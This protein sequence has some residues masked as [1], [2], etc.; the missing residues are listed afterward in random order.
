MLPEILA[1]AMLVL[2]ALAE[3]RHA[4]R[5]HSIRFLAFGPRGKPAAW[6]RSV[7]FIRAVSMTAVTWGL[8]SLLWTVEARTHN[9]DSIPEQDIRHLVLIVDV[10]PSMGLLDAGSAGKLTRRQ[11]ASEIVESVFNRISLRQF[12]ITFIAVYSDAKPLLEDSSDHEVVRHMLESMPMWHAF[13]SGKTNLMSGIELAAKMA[14]PWNPGS[15]SILLLTDGDTVPATGMPQLPASV[16]DFLVIGVGDPANGKFIDGHLSRQDANTLRQVSNRLRGHYHNG[17]EKQIP[18][19]LVDMLSTL[20]A[21]NEDGAWTKHEWAL[22]AIFAGSS[23]L[24]LLPLALHYF[25]TAYVGG[26]PLSVRSET[27]HNVSATI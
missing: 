13:K 8:A 16:R 23:G 12:R 4:R 26:S 2:M 9:R 20:N 3:W 10:S 6:T 22:L 25:G 27:S 11:R 24:A 7:P 19:R 5:V 14:R 15:A 18:S 17:N 21:D 1:F